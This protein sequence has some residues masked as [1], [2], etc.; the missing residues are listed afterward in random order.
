[1]VLNMTIPKNP[2]IEAFPAR[3]FRIS[4]VTATL[5]SF[6]VFAPRLV[7]VPSSWGTSRRDFLEWDVEGPSPAP[8]TTFTNAHWG[9]DDDRGENSVAPGTEVMEATGRVVRGP[10][11]PRMG[12]PKVKRMI[13]DSESR[14]STERTP[15]RHICVRP[16]S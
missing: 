10:F 8:A 2:Y 1:M 14:K 13:F 7:N 5:S 4:C 11:D 16:H 9:K 12:T 3:K 6:P 15:G